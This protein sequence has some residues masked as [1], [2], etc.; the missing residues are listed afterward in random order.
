MSFEC[1]PYQAYLLSEDDE[2]LHATLAL[3]LKSSPIQTTNCTF[4]QVPQIQIS[5]MSSPQILTGYL[6]SSEASSA[7]PFV[8]SE[9]PQHWSNYNHDLNRRDEVASFLGDLHT[10]MP[11]VSLCT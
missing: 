3:I 9:N 2:P 10:T 1:H 5:M 11:L 4:L 6:R 8:Y 7:N